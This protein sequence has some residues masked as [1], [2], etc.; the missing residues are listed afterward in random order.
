MLWLYLLYVYEPA[1]LKMVLI[2]YANSE[3][4]GE[5]VH[6][7]TLTRAFAVR[8]LEEASATKA[9]DLFWLR[10]IYTHVRLKEHRPFDAKVP[11]GSCGSLYRCGI[12]NSMVS[13]GHAHSGLGEIG[14]RQSPEA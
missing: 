14:E 3:D 8:E 4:S 13:F 12:Y 7:R 10:W 1:H 6:L 9:G 2:K 5:P 11:Y